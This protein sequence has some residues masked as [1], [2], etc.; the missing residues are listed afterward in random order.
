MR[1]SYHRRIPNVLAGP[2]IAGRAD[3]FAVG[4]QGREGHESGRW[5]FLRKLFLR[6]FSR[7][8]DDSG[9]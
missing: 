4:A 5:A 6:E 7:T 1:V 2:A 9:I 3:F 8:A